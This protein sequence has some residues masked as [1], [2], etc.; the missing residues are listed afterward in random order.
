MRLSVAIAAVSLSIIGLATADDVRAS[1]KRPTNIPAQAL[2]PALQTLA[3]DR[4]FQVVYVSEEVN[5]L[6]THGAVGEFTSEEAL[7]QLLKGTGLSFRYLDEKTVTI[8]LASAPPLSEASSSVSSP[9]SDPRIAR[10]E[11]GQEAEAQQKS[12][13]SR[14]RLAQ[15]DQ[16]A[17]QGAAGPPTSSSGSRVTAPQDVLEEVTVTANRRSETVLNYAGSVQ[18]L[19]GEALDNP[20]KTGF[21]G[22]LLRVPSVSLREENGVSHITV[23]GVSN[24]SGGDYGSAATSETVGVYINDIPLAG[25]SVLPDL[26]LYDVQRV[27]VLKGPQGTLYGAG[28]MGGAIRILLNEPT[29]EGVTGSTEATGSYTEY[30]GAN[31]TLRGAVNVPINSAVA[32]RLV[33]SDRHDSGFIDNT[34]TG[35]RDANPYDEHS[36]RGLIRA[37]VSPN[38]TAELLLL[39][40]SSKQFQANDADNINAL[41]VDSPEPRFND[42][43]TSLFAL[44]L[45][46][47]LG[48]ADLTSVSSGFRGTRHRVNHLVLGSSLAGIYGVPVTQDNFRFEADVHAFS[49]EIRLVSKGASPLQWVVGAYYQDL[50]HDVTGG[51]DLDPADLVA[52]NTVL[53]QRGLPIFGTPEVWNTTTIQ[54]YSKQGSLYADLTYHFSD[55]FDVFGGL[56]G[57]YEHLYSYQYQHGDGVFS[58]IVS[59]PVV[60]TPNDS[61]FVPRVGLRYYPTAKLMTYGSVSQGYRSSAPNLGYNNFGLGSPGVHPDKATTYELG[62]K[63]E[64]ANG[65]IAVNAAIY[66]IR[67]TKIQLAQTATAVKAPY[68]GLEEGF[69]SNAGNASIN[70]AEVSLEAAPVKSLSLGGS[71]GYNQSRLT[72]ALVPSFVGVELPVTPKWTASGWA[73]YRAPLSGRLDG[74]IGLDAEY[75]GRQLAVLPSSAAVAGGANGDGLPIEPYFSANL[76]VGLRAT[77][78]RMDLFVENL[79]DRRSELGRGLLDST[80]AVNDPNR[81]SI[82]RPRTVGLTAR[83]MF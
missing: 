54:D 1:I 74:E 73:T 36:V 60:I 23:R 13:W 34:A 26:G 41:T 61:G 62:A 81:F 10:A 48:F 7:K 32:M 42:A 29:T 21:E 8:V 51:T 71:I 72:S 43:N 45:A 68:I 69:L 24:I 9:I 18:V 31:Y 75:V 64:S 35:K 79:T 37:Q 70:G 55:K 57:Y 78:W 76:R 82:S 56:R 6:R 50:R 77:E 66:H 19:S 3:K 49:Q 22:Y 47:S 15:V 52:L 38:L 11:G 59:G 80:G 30:G 46:Y 44:T 12:F 5:S 2:G 4:N 58:N 28:S 67:W 63:K 40:D 20:L 39:N 16:S 83:Y 17:K 14:F 65:R 33:A 27:E 25:T 53:F